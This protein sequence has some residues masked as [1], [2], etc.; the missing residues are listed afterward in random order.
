MVETKKCR[1]D[2]TARDGRKYVCQ[3][4]LGHKGC[5]NDNREGF[6]EVWTDADARRIAQR[7][8]AARQQAAKD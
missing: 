1:S 2:V 6:W 4:A 5:H 7:A 8:E 3:K